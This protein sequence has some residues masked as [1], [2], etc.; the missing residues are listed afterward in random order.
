[1]K[2][3]LEPNKLWKYHDIYDL[4][5]D[6]ER[7]QKLGHK[8]DLEKIRNFELGSFGLRTLMDPK[9]MTLWHFYDYFVSSHALILDFV[10][11][12][13]RPYVDKVSHKFTM[14]FH[15][16]ILKFK[17]KMKLFIAYN[18]IVMSHKFIR[19]FQKFKKCLTSSGKGFEGTTPTF[20]PRRLHKEDI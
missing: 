16:F 12:F 7:G 5:F 20:L 4:S 8:G 18:F 6:L 11:L 2:S 10:Y 9:D 15:K 19:V 17:K 3:F 13:N 14:A 1:M